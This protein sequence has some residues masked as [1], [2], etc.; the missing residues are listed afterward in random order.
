MG[1]LRIARC[2]GT[3]SKQRPTVHADSPLSDYVAVSSTD[4][5]DMTRLGFEKHFEIQKGFS[6]IIAYQERT[7]LTVV[8]CLGL[9]KGLLDLTWLQS[10]I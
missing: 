4:S 6:L 9:A 7:E 2:R 10:L 1:T 5:N 3:F 8:P